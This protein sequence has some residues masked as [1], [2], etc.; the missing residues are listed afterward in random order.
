MDKILE[1]LAEFSNNPLTDFF[2]SLGLSANTSK[3]LSVAVAALI[4]W[5]A[6][7]WL[8]KGQQRL[9]DIRTARDLIHFRYS[10]RDVR[11]KRALFI[12]THGQSHS[13]AYEDEPMKGIKFIPKVPLIPFFIKTAFN[14]KKESDKFYLILAD[15]GM[16]KTTFMINLYLQLAC[17]QRCIY[18]RLEGFCASPAKQDDRQ[19]LRRGRG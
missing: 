8:K 2:L 13:P 9:K 12:P 10:Y 15:S 5:Q 4:P 7:V 1:L 19:S 18:C 6:G 16:G 17:G 14:E 11:Q 3:L